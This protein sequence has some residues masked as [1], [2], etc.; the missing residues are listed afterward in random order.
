M[1]QMKMIKKIEPDSDDTMII[2]SG[3]SVTTS[4]EK[5]FNYQMTDKKAKS[6]LIKGASRETMEIEEM[7][8][9]T[10]IS[11]SVGAYHEVVIPSVLELKIGS[12]VLNTEVKEVIPGYDVL[13]C[14]SFQPDVLNGRL[15]Y[16]LKNG[17]KSKTKQGKKS[18]MVLMID[19]GQIEDDQN[20]A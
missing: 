16:S 2:A 7:Q 13:A 18:G 19:P 1:A 4:L 11:F 10:M 8:K 12:K 17:M 14:D 6:N 5:H 3:N 20:Y 15:C 9:C